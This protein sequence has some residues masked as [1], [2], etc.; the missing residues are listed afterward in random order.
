MHKDPYQ[1][2]IGEQTT[3]AMPPMKD[4]QPRSFA[5]TP[6]ANEEMISAA[7]VESLEIH[8]YKAYTAIFAFSKLKDFILWFLIVLEIALALRFFFR[9]IGANADSLFAGFLYALTGIF[10]AP[11]NGIVGTSSLHSNQAFEWSTLIGMLVYCLIFYAVGCF[12]R[13]LVSRPE[14]PE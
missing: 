7:E 13:I 4:L 1:E 12:L 14:T 9:L 6:P 8:G 2:P 5:H 10:L 3:E 11:F